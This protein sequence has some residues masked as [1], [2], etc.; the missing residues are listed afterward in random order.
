VLF[1]RTR[2]SLGLD[3]RDLSFEN[4]KGIKVTPEAM[5]VLPGDDK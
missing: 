3:F 5:G 4:F 2:Q 1:E